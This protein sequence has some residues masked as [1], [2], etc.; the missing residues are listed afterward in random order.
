MIQDSNG[1]LVFFRSI[2]SKNKK[3]KSSSLK[4]IRSEDYAINYPIFPSVSS[5]NIMKEPKGE[6]DFGEERRGFSDSAGFFSIRE[7]IGSVYI[8]NYI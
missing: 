2:G 7:C 5:I 6:V 8:Y 3:I 4:G 1:I